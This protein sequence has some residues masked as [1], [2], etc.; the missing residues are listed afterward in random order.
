MFSSSGQ[1]IGSLTKYPS[2]RHSNPKTLEGFGAKRLGNNGLEE[3]FERRGWKQRR[4]FSIKIAKR[5]TD[6]GLLR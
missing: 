2:S 1:L 6:K 4:I 5:V 3:N